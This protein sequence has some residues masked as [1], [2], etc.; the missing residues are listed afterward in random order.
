MKKDTT[1]PKNINLAPVPSTPVEFETKSRAVSTFNDSFTESQ[2][3]PGEDAALL[4]QKI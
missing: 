3:P 1:K 4:N 2:F